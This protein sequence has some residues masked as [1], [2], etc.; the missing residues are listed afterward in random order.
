MK[1]ESGTE[2]TREKIA[3]PIVMAVIAVRMKKSG[4]T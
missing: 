1:M 2:S 4:L 3:V